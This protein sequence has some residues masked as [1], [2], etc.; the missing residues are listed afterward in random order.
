MLPLLN[1]PAYIYNLTPRLHFRDAQEDQTTILCSYL[2]FHA[3]ISFISNS[4]FRISALTARRGRIR[5]E[6]VH[7]RCVGHKEDGIGDAPWN[8][9]ET[10]KGTHWCIQIKVSNTL[11]ILEKLQPRITRLVFHGRLV[12]VGEEALRLLPF[13]GVLGTEASLQQPPRSSSYH[14]PEHRCPW[15]GRRSYGQQRRFQ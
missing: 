8:Q 12:E 14:S 10:E 13:V 2:K 7:Y 4:Y 9:I 6:T 1:L 3:N 15:G 11:N 5:E